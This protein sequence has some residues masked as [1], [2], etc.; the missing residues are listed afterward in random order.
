M[1]NHVRSSARALEVEE[2]WLAALNDAAIDAT[3]IDADAGGATAGGVAKACPDGAGD[4][5]LGCTWATAAG[6]LRSLRMTAM[7][8][9]AS[10][11]RYGG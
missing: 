3:D 7:Y 9:A 6:D 10:A 8:S 1:E 4:A 2:D 11:V 5:G